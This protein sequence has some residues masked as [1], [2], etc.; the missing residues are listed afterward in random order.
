M[1]AERV[2][3]KC[4]P[5]AYLFSCVSAILGAARS[6]G[7]DARETETFFIGIRTW[8]KQ[9]PLQN[10]HLWPISSPCASLSARSAMLL[11]FYKGLRQPE[12]R[13]ERFQAAFVSD[14]YFCGWFSSHC[15][16]C[17]RVAPTARCFSSAVA[18]PDVIFWKSRLTAG[19]CRLPL[20]RMG[21]GVR[22]PA[23]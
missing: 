21:S 18:S 19:A 2:G 11:R 17:F 20:M 12:S 7:D 8:K 13:A 10:P 5:Y 1:G 23:P 14:G 3:N 15:H 22:S 9:R 16:C 4:P 6:K